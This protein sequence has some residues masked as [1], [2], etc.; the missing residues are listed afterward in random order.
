MYHIIYQVLLV[1]M[2]SKWDSIKDKTFTE[3]E[4]KQ[5]CI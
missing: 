3:G 2:L 1:I 4:K 5:K